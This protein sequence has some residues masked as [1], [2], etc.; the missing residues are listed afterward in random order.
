[1]TRIDCI[2]GFLVWVVMA[3]LPVAALAQPAWK[4]DR[5]VELIV[6]SAP[7]NSNDLMLRLIAQILQ[8][9]RIVEQPVNVL[10]RPG[11]GNNIA[12]NYLNQRAG[13]GHYLMMANLN[14]SVGHL[15]G[16][17]TFSYR[18]FTPVSLLYDE[19][20]VFVVRA[21]SPV[22]TGRDLIERLKKDPGSLS[23]SFSSV[24]GGA[25]HI[26]AGLVFKAAGVDVRK[27][28]T[29]VFDSAGKAITAALGGHVDIVSASASSAVSHMRAGTVRVLAITSPR[30]LEGVFAEVPTWREQG[31]EMS[32]SNYRGLI[33]GRNLPPNQLAYWENVFATLDKDPAWRANLEKNSWAPNYTNS[34]DTRKYW[35]ELSVQMR[36][37]LDELGLLKR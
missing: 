18:D 2:R 26:A 9:K 14:L 34:R 33:A 32:F 16:T 30:R 24:A 31:A 15:T 12:W 36:D 17:T 35:D 1:M 13:D 25:N 23:L 29:V 19:Y 27:V 5:P 4:P 20:V 28:R 22:K 7:G 11:G 21:D 6:G 3:A 10:N 8:E 37:T